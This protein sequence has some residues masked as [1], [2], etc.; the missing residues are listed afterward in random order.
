MGMSLSCSYGDIYVVRATTI[1][2]G[3]TMLITSRKISVTCIQFCLTQVIK[4]T[5]FHSSRKLDQA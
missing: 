3:S 5:R 1:A 4:V 2:E